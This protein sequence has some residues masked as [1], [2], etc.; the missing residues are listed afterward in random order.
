MGWIGV[1]VVVR[2]ED[3]GGG[4]DWR[5]VAKR[6]KLETSICGQVGGVQT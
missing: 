1:G 4:R 6:L 3:G 2:K 5:C